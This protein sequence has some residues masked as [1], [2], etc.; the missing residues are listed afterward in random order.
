MLFGVSLFLSDY[1]YSE[2]IR[3]A[4]SIT[5]SLPIIRFREQFQIFREGFD[6]D[7]IF[8]CDADAGRCHATSSEPCR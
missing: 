2:C 1:L 3:L 4:S 7:E 6:V 8:D 5:S